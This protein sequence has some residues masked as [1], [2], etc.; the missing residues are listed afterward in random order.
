M[1]DK[2]LVSACLLGSPVRYDG[3]DKKLPSALLEHWAAEGRLVAICPELAGGLPVPRAPAEIQA[4]GRVLDVAGGDVSDAFGEGAR[5]ALALAQS[6]GCRFALLTDGS[7]S[8]GSSFVYD[9]SFSGARVAGMG[10]T[11]ALL[12][13][14]GIRVFAPNRI[15][16]LAALL[17]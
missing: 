2:V 17:G 4:E 15:E 12:E 7:P 14:S 8:C 13:T 11:A 5:Q 10:V 6:E 3:R 9:G 16:E 1:P